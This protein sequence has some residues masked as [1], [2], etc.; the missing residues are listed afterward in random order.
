LGTVTAAGTIVNDDVLP[1]LSIAATSASLNEGNSGSTIHAFTVTRSGDTSGAASANWTVGSSTAT[2]PDFEGGQLP[3]GTVRF[4]AGETSTTVTIAVA[5]DTAF[6]ADEA[7]TVTLSAPSGAT[8]GTVTAAGTIVNDDALPVLAIA[9][10]ASS[11]NE[12]NG[13]TTNYNFTVTRSGDTSGASSANW[14]VSSGS[15]SG[16]DFIDGALPSGTVSFVAGETSKPITVAVAGDTAFEADEAFTVTLS[17]PSGAK[18]GTVT[19]AGII[20]NDDALPTL[21]IAARDANRDEGNDNATDFTFTVTRSGDTSGTS[22]ASWAVGVASGMETSAPEDGAIASAADFADGTLPS[23]TVS[24]AAGESSKIVTVVVVGDTAFEP[25]ETFAVTLS[26]PIGGTVGAASTA[27][28]T[29]LNDDTAVVPGVTVNGTAG[30][31]SALTGGA[32]ND[33]ITG[34][35]GTDTLT[36]TGG[37]DRLDGGSGL[38]SE[39]D[40]AI[41]S[42]PISGYTLAR[43]GATLTIADATPGRDGT[44]TATNLEKLQF[45]DMGVNL[46]VQATAASIDPATLD[47]ICELYLGFFARV[48]AADGIENWVN[49]F[50]AGKSLNAIA[51]D[52]YGIGSSEAL[53]SVTGYWDFTN[54][55]PL[56]DQDFVRIAYRNVLGREGL[57]GGITYWAAELTGPQ[58]KTRG[59]LVGTMLDAAR[60]LTGDTTWGWVAQLLDDKVLMS[61]RVAVDWG[62]NYGA[63]ASEAITKGVEIANAI[64]ESPNPNPAFAA[65]PV[66]TFDFAEATA[67]IGINPAGIDL[68][69]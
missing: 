1:T 69:A 38:P 16:T 46:T 44:D 28:G 49:Q 29:I 15:A 55:R 11:Q 41:F 3:S 59:E 35:A 34:F 20:V 27:T 52:F 45:S 5:G 66:K 14:A 54:D 68:I 47:R 57:E 6:E 7:F 19:A 50:K 24:F 13:G 36:G 51:D 22:S 32:G 33:T 4:A 65:I 40:L 31:D 2:G 12:G 43:A 39:R 62:L 67:L 23:G 9:P 63:N 17:A 10:T 8:L 26:N 56:S 42:G 61:K 18:L 25:D 21:S 48:P 30:N 64:D 60:G 37:D 53:R 58:A